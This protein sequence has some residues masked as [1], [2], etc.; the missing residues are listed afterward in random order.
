M[1]SWPPGA[2]PPEL[3]RLAVELALDAADLVAESV[4]GDRGAMT[5][6]VT[7]KSTATD[8]VTDADR[9][10]EARL[11]EQIARAR[12]ATP[13]S[14]RRAVWA[15]TNRAAVSHDTGSSAG[16]GSAR[17]RRGAGSWTPSTA[18]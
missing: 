1:T 3:E 10:A 5:D 6:S 11:R 14:V 16:T 15:P 17:V 2:A 7:T 18:R 9:R 4:A 8:L 12:P 13:C